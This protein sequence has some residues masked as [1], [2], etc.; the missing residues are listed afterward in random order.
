MSE[1]QTH[2]EQQQKILAVRATLNEK[3]Q[4]H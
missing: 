3:Q 2:L 4:D 1:K